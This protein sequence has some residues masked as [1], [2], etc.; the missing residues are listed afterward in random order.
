MTALEFEIINKYKNEI[1][2]DFNKYA[3]EALVDHDFKVADLKYLLI[4]SENKNI[5]LQELAIVLNVDK[6]VVTRTIK[7]LVELDYVNKDIDEKDSR[8]FNLSLTKKSEKKLAELKS[9]F[10]EWYDKLTI[11]FTEDEKSMYIGIMKK[12]YENRIYK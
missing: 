4:I 9:I 10:K 3:Q 6:A 7:R 12:A 11:N 5:K 8:S 1:I 2:K